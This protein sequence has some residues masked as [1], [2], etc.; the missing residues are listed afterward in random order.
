MFT[1]DD[2]ASA[3]RLHSAPCAELA[4][5][6][7]WRVHRANRAMGGGVVRFDGQRLGTAPEQASVFAAC[8]LSRTRTL[9]RRVSANLAHG[10]DVSSATYVVSCVLPVRYE[11]GRPVA[12]PEGAQAWNRAW[13]MEL[14][15]KLISHTGAHIPAW[16]SYPPNPARADEEPTLLDHHGDQVQHVVQ[17]ACL[18]HA[19]PLYRTKDGPN[20]CTSF[21]L[22]FN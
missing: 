7:G 22:H 13:S 3:R 18:R 6:C 4:Y 14:A 9:T 1:A 20:R 15:V 8:I 16:A 2:G 12:R 5:R 10:F 21:W 11:C 19:A 17:R